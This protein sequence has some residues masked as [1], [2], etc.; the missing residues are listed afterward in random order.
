MVMILHALHPEF[1]RVR[2]Q[3]ST[4]QEVPSKE[5]LNTQLLRI[6]TLQDQNVQTIMVSAHERGGCNTKGE[7]GGW[8][9]PKCRY[10]WYSS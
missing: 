10:S 4:S 6:P 9:C 8:E 7:C 2:D 1:D 5:C 3:L